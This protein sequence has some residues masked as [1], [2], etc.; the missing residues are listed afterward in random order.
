MN[1]RRPWMK[2]ALLISM[3]A[4]VS[5]LVPFTLAYVFDQSD[6]LVNTFA[7]PMGLNEQTAVEVG[8]TKTVI[9][10][11]NEVMGPDGFRFTLENIMTA[12]KI[13]A[14]SD[15]KGSAGFVL[16]YTGVDTGK[17]FRYK[18]YEENDGAERV[19]YSNKVYIL[20]VEL[21]MVEGKPVAKVT[22]DGQETQN[23]S[24]RFVNEYAGA[25]VPE[26]GDISHLGLYALLLLGGT[27]LM[28]LLVR[29]WRKEN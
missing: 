18:V 16:N 28:V 9:N 12:E 29:S 14:V 24:L 15:D 8:I 13:T 4:V 23:C 26:T 27:M 11:G 22:V 25:S 3:V 21:T 6:S 19:T 17:S 1:F 10:T 20:Q 2:L 7:P 5:F